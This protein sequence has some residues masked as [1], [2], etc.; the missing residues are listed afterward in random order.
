MG[1]SSP[2]LR[3]TCFGVIWFISREKGGVFSPRRPGSPGTD[4]PWYIM[5]ISWY[6]HDVLH[7][8][9]PAFHP[10]SPP[11]FPYLRPEPRRGPEPRYFG[12]LLATRTS[13]WSI[14]WAQSSVGFSSPFGGLDVFGGR[15]V[16]PQSDVY[17]LVRPSHGPLHG[18]TWHKSSATLPRMLR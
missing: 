13:P 14:L 5:P 17:S 16:G 8:P 6:T 1:G 4:T 9:D 3:R 10:R 11:P 12:L 2:I 18:R 15:E 7:S